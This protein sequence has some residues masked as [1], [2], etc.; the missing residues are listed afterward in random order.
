MNPCLKSL[1]SLELIQLIPTRQRRHAVLVNILNPCLN[2]NF[3]VHSINSPLPA[4]TT[5]CLS[6]Y[7][8]A[9]LVL[10]SYL[11]ILCIPLCRGGGGES[12]AEEAGDI[13]AREKEWK[14]RNIQAEQKDLYKRGKVKVVAVSWETG[15][16]Q[17][18]AALA[19]LHQDKLKNRLIS[20]TRLGAKQFCPP[21]KQRRPLPSRL[22]KSFFCVSRPT[23]PPPPPPPIFRAA[24]G[25][26]PSARSDGL[27]G[28]WLDSARHASS[29]HFA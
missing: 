5:G 13:L 24:P 17:F 27:A 25:G 8:S 2:E 28:S 21:N 23:P 14:Q 11:T 6:S 12:W 9:L 7:L 3:G 15:L 26:R 16:I 22:Y 4:T 18:L 29:A 20:S 19:I 10:S 1:K